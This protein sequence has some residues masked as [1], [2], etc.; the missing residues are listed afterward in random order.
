LTAAGEGIANELGWVPLMQRWLD[1][2]RRPGVNG[3]AD[4]PSARAIPPTRKLSEGIAFLLDL[5]MPA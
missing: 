2:A 4:E 5:P 1:V 3:L